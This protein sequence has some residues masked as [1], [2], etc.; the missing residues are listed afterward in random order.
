M[1]KI[2]LDNWPFPGCT[3]TE[4]VD[5]EDAD[6]ILEVLDTLI[7]TDPTQNY[8]LSQEDVDGLHAGI[9]M[10]TAFQEGR[11]QIPNHWNVS[12][13]TVLFKATSIRNNSGPQIYIPGLTC[14]RG[15][16]YDS[17]EPN[18]NWLFRKVMLSDDGKPIMHFGKEDLST[19]YRYLVFRRPV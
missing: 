13:L 17:R 2:T 11:Y 16:V 9:G 8:Y 1:D 10:Y 3:A 6:L 19:Y 15:L 14:I 12:G 18:Q 4:E 5:T 7:G